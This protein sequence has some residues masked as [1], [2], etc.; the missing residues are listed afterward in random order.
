MQLVTTNQQTNPWELMQGFCYSVS[1]RL[2]HLT[3]TNLRTMYIIKA[4][5]QD[6]EERPRR[7]G[8]EQHRRAFL[9]RYIFYNVPRAAR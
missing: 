6:V 5:Q 8:G 7:A 4:T 3:S 1:L 2:N 9:D